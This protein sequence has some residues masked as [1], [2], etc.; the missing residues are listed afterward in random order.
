MSG[1]AAFLASVLQQ[2]LFLNPSQYG[3][4]DTY[5]QHYIPLFIPA[6]RVASVEVDFMYPVNQKVAEEATN[7]QEVR[8]KRQWQLKSLFK[9]YHRLAKAL[10]MGPY[11]E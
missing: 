11:A 7:N 4:A 9:D 3:I 1:P 5:I 10:K 8:K 6:D 2:Y